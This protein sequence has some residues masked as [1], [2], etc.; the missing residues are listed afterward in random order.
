VEAYLVAE[1]RAQRRLAAILVADV[2]GY[3]RLMEEDETGT[4]ST[5]RER[6]ASILEPTI[7]ENDGRI[8]RL[9]G[10][11]VLVE[12]ASVINAVNCAAEMQKR[13]T[14]ANAGLPEGRQIILRIG[15]N[16]GDVIV[17]GGDLY[18][19]GVNI[20]ARLQALAD[21]G[22]IY[23]SR[24]VFDNVRNK[25]ELQFENLG[26]R[27][28]KNIREPVQLYRVTGIVPAEA[29]PSSYTGASKP[30][31][32][33]L[34][35]ENLGGDPEQSY[36]ADGM[37]NDIILELS[38]FQDL[39]V[40]AS[41]SVFTFKGRQASL[42][43]VARQLGVRYVVEGSVR[44]VGERILINV[45]LMATDTERNLWAE[46]YDF[47]MVEL[48]AV[49][50]EIVRAIASRLSTRL[51]LSERRR[52][53]RKEPRSV[54][55][56]DC[57]LR[58]REYW[59]AWSP[60]DNLQSQR[61]FE[62]AIRLDPTFARAYGMLSYS[63]VQA[64][65]CGWSQEPQATLDR[66]HE[67]AQ[68]AVALGGDDYDNYWSL[69]VV[70]LYRH[71]Y[72]RAFAFYARALAANPNYPNLLVDFAEA[73]VYVGRAEEAIGRIR[74]A[75][76]FNPIHPDWYDWVLALA[77]FHSGRYAE[78]N[79]ALQAMVDPPPFYRPLGVATLVRLGRREE[80]V[81]AARELLRVDAGYTV[82]RQYLLP[83]K[84]VED[85][86]AYVSSLLEAGLK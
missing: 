86:D 77:S 54:D 40:I 76:R 60:D 38:R 16:I 5:M 47:A 34:P 22:G 20:A 59:F 18:G 42:Q 19:D 4:H 8:I 81:A 83:Y 70:L 50:D 10:D 58:G 51:E 72:E 31:I 39:F 30:S 37:T 29:I 74:E 85:R 75:M 33:V 21:P 36:F 35:F 64:Y 79:E 28:V 1:E 80:A 82:A 53:F 12:F 45:W 56:Y 41:H 17:E 62:K 71:E 52:A 25:V 57:Y 9:M 7:A 24:T 27:T 84:R 11:G 73:L 69:A 15:I 13:M 23:V 55:A 67:L 14:A 48:F 2:V 46:R 68:K 78:A 44:R 3:S 63:L 26:E 43:E 32:A 49:Q 66:A 6:Q 65:F 61:D